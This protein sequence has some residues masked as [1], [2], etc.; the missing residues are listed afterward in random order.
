MRAPFGAFLVPSMIASPLGVAAI[1]HAIDTAAAF[2]GPVHMNY[3]R[4]NIREFMCVGWQPREQGR[5]KRDSVRQGAG[6]R[7][8]RFIASTS[9]HRVRVAA[10]QLGRFVPRNRS[11][12]SQTI[13]DAGATE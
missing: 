3:I 11:A 7:S 5:H 13:V 4:R 1:P 12:A 10:R 9:V 6:T 2:A 8:S